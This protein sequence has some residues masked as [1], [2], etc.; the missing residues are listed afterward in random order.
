MSALHGLRVLDLTR[1]LP[2]P[3]CTMLL[4]DL[5]ADVVKVEEPSAGDPL[6]HSPPLHDDTSALFLLVNRN[7]RSLTLDLKTTEGHELF[8]RLVARADVLVEGFRPGVMDRLG[9]GYDQVARNNPRLIYASLSGFGQAGPYRDRPGHD[10]NYL[11]LAGVLGYNVDRD[12]QPVPPAVQIADLGAGTLAALAI[13][14]AVVSRQTTGHGQS[15]DVSLFASAFAWLP[16]LVAPLFGQGRAAA[17]GEPVLAGGLPQYNVYATAD[18]R[19]I[20]LGA[21]EPRFLRTFLE[22]VGR[23]ELADVTDPDR[24][25]RELET[26]FRSRTLLEWRES[27]A[28]VDTCFGP[29][30][31]LEEAV[32]DPQ[33][34]ALGLLTSIEHPR[35]GV[36][37][38]ISP[39]F[40]FSHTPALVRRPP[41]ELGEHSLEIL[42]ELGLTPEQVRDL[43]NRRVV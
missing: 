24:L 31:T 22:H 14:A 11:A 3:F 21:L 43:A 8:M 38:Q 41:P 40:V 37:P 19:F 42:G 13:L 6:R 39:P 5:G 15:V 9:A 35:L 27:L 23:P 10:L 33:V 28:D 29:V 1:L 20:S 18:A 25:R 30:N 2:G 7:K 16:T 12:G 26:I 36:L 34:R 32:Q 17:P 4:A